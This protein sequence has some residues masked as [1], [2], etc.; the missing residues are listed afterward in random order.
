MSVPVL[1]ASGSSV[2]VCDGFDND[3]DGDLDED[4][5]D[6]GLEC[7]TEVNGGRP[8]QSKSVIRISTRRKMR[9]GIIHCDC[10]PD[11]TPVLPTVLLVSP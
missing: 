6:L 3:C 11:V 1:C 2:E 7:P 8:L 10:C 5:E 4:F 9:R